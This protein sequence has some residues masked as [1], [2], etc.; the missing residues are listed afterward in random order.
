MSARLALAAAA[1]LVPAAPAG[2]VS[3]SQADANR[4]GV[5][6]F[7]EAVRVFPLLKRVQYEKCDADGD[8]VIDRGDFALLNNFYW[9][10]YIQK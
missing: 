8:G 4:D 9:L 7:E 1:L 6:T 5:V 2:A 10:T 3:F